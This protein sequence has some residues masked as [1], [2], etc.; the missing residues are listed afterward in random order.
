MSI[1]KRVVPLIMLNAA[2]N[3]SHMSL[4]LSSMTE[5]EKDIGSLKSGLKSIEAVSELGD[6]MIHQLACQ[7]V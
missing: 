4:C 7:S 1:K 3:D 6:S 5:L 2:A